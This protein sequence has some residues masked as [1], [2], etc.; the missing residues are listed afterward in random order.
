MALISEGVYVKFHFGRG[1]FISIISYYKYIFFG[2]WSMSL[3][4]PNMKLMT[5]FISLWSFWQ[6]KNYVFDHEVSCK[7]YFK[8]NIRKEIYLFV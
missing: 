5:G 8:W 7:H 3:I 1:M 2:V 6:E 4:H